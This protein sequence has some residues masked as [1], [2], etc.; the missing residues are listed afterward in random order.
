MLDNL[1]SVDEHALDKLN[2]LLQMDADNTTDWTF[3]LQICF[4]QNRKKRLQIHSVAER[5]N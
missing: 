5:E 3:E 4:K 1:I 2:L